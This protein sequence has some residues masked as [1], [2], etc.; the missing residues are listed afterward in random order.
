MRRK[1][2]RERERGEIWNPESMWVLDWRGE[3][4]RTLGSGWREQKELVMEKGVEQPEGKDGS[5]DVV[6]KMGSLPRGRRFQCQEGAGLS[7]S[8]TIYKL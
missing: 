3:E 4:T 6:G 8:C 5:W 2:E 7:P 1:R